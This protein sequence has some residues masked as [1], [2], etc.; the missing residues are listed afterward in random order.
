MRVTEEVRIDASPVSFVVPGLRRP[1]GSIFCWQN[2]FRDLRL[3][4][5]EGLS[6]SIH[7][8]SRGAALVRRLEPAC[9]LARPLPLRQRRMCSFVRSRQRDARGRPDRPM[10]APTTQLTRSTAR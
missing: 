3:A 1:W 7:A 8:N 4:A 6:R 5:P 2:L 10:T 9:S